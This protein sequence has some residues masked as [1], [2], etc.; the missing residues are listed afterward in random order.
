MTEF[1][2]S[3][4]GYYPKY[5]GEHNPKSAFS[6]KHMGT[7][8]KNQ[9]VTTIKNCTAEI[10]FIVFKRIRKIPNWYRAF[11]SRIEKLTKIPMKEMLVPPRTIYEAEYKN[12]KKLNL[13]HGT[14]Y[15]CLA[16]IIWAATPLWKKEPPNYFRIFMDN[17]QKYLGKGKT[18]PLPTINNATLIK[19]ISVSTQTGIEKTEKSCQTDIGWPTEIGYQA[20]EPMVW[21]PN[22]S[23]DNIEAI[24]TSL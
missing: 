3:P 17:I 19:K 8:T 13:D 7:I 24:Y 5:I 21:M 14:L 2:P 6:M 10:K 15:N 18:I 1:I 16:K 4:Q 11:E 20:Q 9:L 23:L 12:I 22:L